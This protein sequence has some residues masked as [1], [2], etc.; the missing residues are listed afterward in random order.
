LYRGEIDVNRILNAIEVVVRFA[1][2]ISAFLVL[3]LIISMITEVVARYV[4]DAPTLW[5]YETAY[6]ITGSFFLLGIGYTLQIGGHVKVD[7]LT[8]FLSDRA[9]LVIY[10]FGY[11]VT[12][13]FVIWATLGLTESFLETYENGE[14]TG[15][16]AWNPVLWPFR[17]VAAFG[18]LLF[19][20][21][22][23]VEIIRNTLR[24]IRGEPFVRKDSFL[25]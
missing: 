18:F 20:V 12:A 19:A 4:F 25:G 13:A 10:I 17:A 7:F 11:C 2:Y 22:L 23:I 6:F 9:N 3:P 24:L 5:A 14:T 21:Q 16:S 1:G 8:D 15:E